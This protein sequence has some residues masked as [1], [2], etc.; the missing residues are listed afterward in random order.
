[1]LLNVICDIIRYFKKGLLLICIV[2]IHRQ[3]N[4]KIW[5]IKKNF[6]FLQI[7]SP[8]CLNKSCYLFSQRWNYF[9][10]LYFLSKSAMQ[11]L[12]NYE[13]E[14]IVVAKIK[15]DASL[16]WSIS[17]ASRASMIEELR[18]SSH[19]YMTLR[20]TLLRS[21]CHV[22]VLAGCDFLFHLQMSKAS[23]EGSC[24]LA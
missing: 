9:K 7:E 8:M 23:S 2:Q 17:P 16:L 13:A 22:C 1:M 11:F 24:D 19:I 5:T 12:M 20:W 18:N 21:V 10:Y 15:S 6:N 4:I 3:M 14:D